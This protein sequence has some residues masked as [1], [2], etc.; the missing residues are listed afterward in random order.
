[1]GVLIFMIAVMSA[2][3]S[4]FGV[5]ARGDGSVVETV[6]IRGERYEYA[7]DGV[8]K[9]NGQRVVS[10]GIGWDIV[11]LFVTVPVVCIV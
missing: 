9:Y 6:S 2:I 8:Y 10:E 5:F 11:T 7:N 1:M 3:A 4:A